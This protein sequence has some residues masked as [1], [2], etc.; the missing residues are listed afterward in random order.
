[1]YRFVITKLNKYFFVGIK[2]E[3]R[4]R[5][6]PFRITMETNAIRGVCIGQ[7]R[8]IVS[9][10]CCHGYA[11]VCFVASLTDC[12]SVGISTGGIYSDDTRGWLNCGWLMADAGPEMSRELEI[13]ADVSTSAK[14]Q[15]SVYWW[16]AKSASRLPFKRR[17][18]VVQWRLYAGP[19]SYNYAQCQA[20]VGIVSCGHGVCKMKLCSQWCGLP[21]VA[22][23]GI[24]TRLKIEGNFTRAHLDHVDI[25]TLLSIN[26]SLCLIALVSNIFFVYIISDT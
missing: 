9:S 13:V 15:Y 18:P 25:Q 22:T 19:T 21:A 6:K 4:L 2:Q 23:H 16:T 17:P 26:N 8:L 14:S 20:N 1:M 11:K 12:M 3:L 24:T 7:H 5:K 10:D